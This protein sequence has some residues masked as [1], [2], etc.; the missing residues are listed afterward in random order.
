[1]IA[2]LSWDLESVAV[3]L[4]EV[5][6]ACAGSAKKRQLVAHGLGS[7]VAICL[8]DQSTSVAGMAHV[9]LPGADPQGKA[10]A[11]FALS[12]LPA[13]FEAMTAG[14]ASRNTRGY[15]ARIAGGAKI[16]AIG[17]SG[18]LP[19]IGDKNV[20]AVREALVAAGVRIV[21]EDTGGGKGRTVWFDPTEAG[22]IRVRAV[23]AQERQI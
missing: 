16:L 13:L 19:R 21:A 14:G 17:G 2:A 3:G 23:G 12:A 20:E 18:A 8:W 11:K 5:A 1:M 15:V 10:N 7:C 6:V 9:V 22:R 4:G